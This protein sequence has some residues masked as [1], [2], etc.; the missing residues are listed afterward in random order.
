MPERVAIFNYVIVPANPARPSL[1]VNL[2]NGRGLAHATQLWHKVYHAVMWELDVEV[3]LEVGN[4][5]VGRRLLLRVQR[6]GVA[7][8]GASKLRCVCCPLR[9]K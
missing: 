8:D 6:I 1:G 2:G 3:S 7:E 9:V 5:V 4:V